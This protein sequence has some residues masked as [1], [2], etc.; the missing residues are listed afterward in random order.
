MNVSF[1]IFNYKWTKE[2]NNSSGNNMILCPFCFSNTCWLFCRVDPLPVRSDILD[3]AMKDSTIT[4]V[5]GDELKMDTDDFGRDL[6]SASLPLDLYSLLSALNKMQSTTSAQKLPNP[7]SVLHLG[8]ILANLFYLLLWKHSRRAN[9]HYLLFR[10]FTV[11]YKQTTARES[12]NL[13]RICGIYSIITS[14]LL[15]SIRVK[16][17]MG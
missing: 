5:S 1:H 16:K 4:V 17:K 12:S 6:V 9:W 3:S 13:A 10:T 14:L 15:S 7:L 11:A 8:D 2:Q